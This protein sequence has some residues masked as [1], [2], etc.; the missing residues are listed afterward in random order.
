MTKGTSGLSFG[1]SSASAALSMSL[2]SRLAERMESY[3]SPEYSLTWKRTRIAS[4]LPVYV[5]RASARRTSDPGFTGWPTPNAGPQND[6]DTTWQERRERLKDEHK[7]GN[8]FGMT[9]G[10]AAQLAGWPTTT[11]MGHIDRAD[12]RPSR[13]ATGRTGGYI[14]EVLAGWLTPSANED[15]AGTLAGNMQQMLSHQAQLAGL[16]SAPYVAGTERPDASRLNPRFSLWLMGLPPD[17]WAS[18]AERATRSSRRLP[19]SS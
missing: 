11:T 8:G 10:M 14:A 13:K 17:A 6:T 1:D 7:N 4:G 9:L 5:Q 12:L 15:A 19:P 16:D 18:C 3:G 2:G